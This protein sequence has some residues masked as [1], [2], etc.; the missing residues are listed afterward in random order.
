MIERINNTNVKEETK[1]ILCTDV[2]KNDD[3]IFTKDKLRGII[4]MG[5]MFSGI[6]LAAESK[7]MSLL[8]DEFVNELPKE[9]GSNNDVKPASS[10]DLADDRKE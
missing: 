4:E 7:Q 6:S 5:K 3:K 10:D 8:E 9:E 2:L 1:D